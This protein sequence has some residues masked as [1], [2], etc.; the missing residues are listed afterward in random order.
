M[1]NYGLAGQRNGGMLERYLSIEPNGL[2]Q[3][4]HQ[5]NQLFTLPGMIHGLG[6]LMN[7]VEKLRGPSPVLLLP[8]C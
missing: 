8:G 1:V 7:I 5:L 2:L 6:F 3:V 4:L